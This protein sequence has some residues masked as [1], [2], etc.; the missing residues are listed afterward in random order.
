MSEDPQAAVMQAQIEATAESVA[1]IALHVSRIDRA[2]R[3]NGSRV[4]FTKHE[5]LE[6]RVT[7]LEEFTTEIK[8]LRRWIFTGV[9]ALVCSVMWS[10]AQMYLKAQ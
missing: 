6:T 2:L 10:A 1:D 7:S 9:A 4:L 5:L 3:G 8:A